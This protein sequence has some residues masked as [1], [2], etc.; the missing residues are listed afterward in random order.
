MI[1]ENAKRGRGPTK[2]DVAYKKQ[3]CVGLNPRERSEFYG[4]CKFGEDQ[5]VECYADLHYINEMF[6]AYD[7]AVMCKDCPHCS[8]MYAH[9][10]YEIGHAP[11][12]DR[13]RAESC[14]DGFVMYSHLEDYI[15]LDDPK[16]FVY[17]LDDGEFIK[18]GKAKNVQHRVLSI[19]TGNARKLIVKYLIPCKS[20][21]S[22]FEV[23]A[24]L[25]HLYERYRMEGEW[26]DIKGKI[27][28]ISFSIFKP[29][30]GWV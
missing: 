17:F 16:A 29:E 23:E 12:Y 28:P 30:Q 20:E 5:L 4:I 8:A 14:F 7:F 26:F 13:F 22:A 21:K 27:D 11:L 1:P 2:I 9:N 24:I 6:N 15:D 25:H 19:Q 18:I 3:R 10:C